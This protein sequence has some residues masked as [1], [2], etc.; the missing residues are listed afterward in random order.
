MLSVLQN[1]SALLLP[2]GAFSNFIVT[3]VF[4]LLVCIEQ[5]VLLADCQC[6]QESSYSKGLFVGITR[7][8]WWL[9]EYCCLSR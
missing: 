2:D 9:S 5:S 4:L 7:H 8:A 1:K 6:C 3:C